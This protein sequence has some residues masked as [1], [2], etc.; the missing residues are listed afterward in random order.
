MNYNTKQ[1]PH[2]LRS[3]RAKQGFS[4]EYMAKQL[5]ISQ[6][7]YS[8]WENEADL[9]S[10]CCLEQICTVLGVSIYEVIGNEPSLVLELQ[11]LRHEVC[12]LQNI[13]SKF[14]PPFC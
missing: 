2:K 9:L 14:L 3:L 13:I 8:R 5:N 10:F 6:K 12:S 11:S 7:T 1:I 4:Q